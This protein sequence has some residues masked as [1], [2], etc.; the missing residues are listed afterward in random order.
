M[1]AV[2]IG[3]TLPDLAIAPIDCASVQE[4]AA[5]SS[6]DNRLHLDDDYARSIGLAGAVVH[7]SYVMGLTER[8]LRNWS[9]AIEVRRIGFQ[10]VRPVAH[11][12][13]LLITGRIAELDANRASIRVTVR[14]ADNAIRCIGMAE[15]ILPPQLT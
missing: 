12:T 3:D 4:Y 13:A 10:F 2:R 6:D 15:C 9:P 7:G 1:S 5:A 11:G 8:L 14:G